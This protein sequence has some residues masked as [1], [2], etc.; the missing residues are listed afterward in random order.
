MPKKASFTGRHMVPKLIGPYKIVS[1]V[2]IP[3]MALVMTR[4]KQFVT[5][6]HL[7]YLALDTLGAMPETF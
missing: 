7:E 3:I 1:A 4:S 6:D 5:I 2:A